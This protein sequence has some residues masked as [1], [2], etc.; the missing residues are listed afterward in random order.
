MD[1]GTGV[2]P[3]MRSEASGE[4]PSMAGE[5]ISHTWGIAGFM[6]LLSA[7]SV[8]VLDQVC[9]GSLRTHRLSGELAHLFQAAEHFGTP[10]GAGLIL[11]T[12]WLTQA[13]LRSR[14]SRTF[15]AAVVAGLLAD[16]VK[17][18]VS[19]TRPKVFDFDQSIWSSFT[20]VFRGGAGG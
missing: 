19:R 8:A 3:R 13:P 6:L 18:C 16:L 14:V 1:S 10:Y 5:P 20:G 11:I 4:N 9:S 17:L 12:L 15:V 2:L 7:A